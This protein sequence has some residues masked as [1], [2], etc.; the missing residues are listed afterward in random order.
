[1]ED[2]RYFLKPVGG[3]EYETTKDQYIMAE[4]AANFFPKSGD[5]VACGSFTGEKMSGRTRYIK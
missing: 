1:M 2:R 5:G 3:S 4:R